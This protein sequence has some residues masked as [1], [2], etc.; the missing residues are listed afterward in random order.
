MASLLAFL[1]RVFCTFS[2]PADYLKSNN[3]SD[4][5]C[6]GENWVQ[7]A[8]GNNFSQLRDKW[9]IKLDQPVLNGALTDRFWGGVYLF[10]SALT[11]SLLLIPV[12]GLK[13]FKN[14]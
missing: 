5:F 1:V 13:N 4:L 10:V 2:K 6:I 9:N 11:L 14:T 12:F 7:I 3:E 8:G